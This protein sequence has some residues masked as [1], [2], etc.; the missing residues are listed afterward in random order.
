MD[1]TWLMER[2][3]LAPRNDATLKKT[4]GFEKEYIH[5]WMVT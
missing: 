2:T 1:P 5:S 4:L 3:I